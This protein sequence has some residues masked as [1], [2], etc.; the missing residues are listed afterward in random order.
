MYLTLVQYQ[1]LKC[2][3]LQGTL[4]EFHLAV[5]VLFKLYSNVGVDV[6]RQFVHPRLRQLQE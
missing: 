3:A 1:P 2:P 5:A 4:L 6:A